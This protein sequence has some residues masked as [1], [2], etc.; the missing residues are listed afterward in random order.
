[1]VFVSLKYDIKKGF[2][3]SCYFAF[4]KMQN[5]NSEKMIGQQGRRISNCDKL[6]LTQLLLP[7]YSFKRPAF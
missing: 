2:F 1:M 6:Y 7:T 5:S 3:L 4:A